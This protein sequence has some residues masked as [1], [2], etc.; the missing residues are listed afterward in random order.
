MSIYHAGSLS[1]PCINIAWVYEHYEA[2]YLVVINQ[3]KNDNLT[4][5]VHIV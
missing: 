3:N 5:D 1:L 2:I 4:L